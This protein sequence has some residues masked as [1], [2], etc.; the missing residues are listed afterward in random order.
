M[1]TED[2]QT[3]ASLNPDASGDMPKRCAGDRRILSPE[4]V[5]VLRPFIPKLR[6]RYYDLAV[7]GST[8][9]PDPICATLKHG[10]R[11]SSCDECPVWGISPG[12][13][14]LA[15][16]PEQ[17]AAVV[18]HHCE[19]YYPERPQWVEDVLGGIHTATGGKY[20]D[21]NIAQARSWGLAVCAWL[22]KLKEE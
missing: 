17:R 1:P 22:E 11:D 20:A 10:K 7:H 18:W 8:T 4:Q 9:L 2:A 21:S 6:A 16:Q 19:D 3:Q 13:G 12:C 14:A 5:A 15:G